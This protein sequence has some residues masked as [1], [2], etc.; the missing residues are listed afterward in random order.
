MMPDR[1]EPRWLDAAGAAAYVS[2]TETA[3]RRRVS[4]GTFPKPNLAAGS[5]SPRWDRLALDATF[6]GGA[7]STDARTAFQ[8]LAN[9]IAAEGRR[10]R[11]QARPG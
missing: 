1:A 2:M 7:D 4:L 10:S 3:F 9:E 8:G 6:D 11:R 5:Q